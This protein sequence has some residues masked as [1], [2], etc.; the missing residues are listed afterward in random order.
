MIWY[1]AYGSNLNHA[2]F[3]ERLGE[4][5]NHRSAYLEDYELRFSGEV[6]SEGGGGAIVQPAAGKRVLGGAYAISHDQIA[7]LDEVE[8]ESAM[9]AA[10]RGIRSTVR[11]R[12][13]DGGY[14]RAQL[15]EVP[16][17]KVYRAPSASY[18]GLVTS[19]LRDFGYDDEAIA[20]VEAI[21][22]EE[23]AD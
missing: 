13:D 23:P 4:W 11:L 17:P 10:G 5:S 14:L 12:T 15:Y 16:A 6:E 8:L 1:F 21:A 22:A 19:G 20:T 7:L 18:L 2:R 9:N 3:K